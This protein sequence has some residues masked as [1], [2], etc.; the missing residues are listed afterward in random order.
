MCEYCEP[1]HEKCIEGEHG[2][3]YITKHGE[4]VVFP[5]T[6]FEVC[7]VHLPIKFC[8]MCGRKYGDT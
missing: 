3:A 4:I 5:D 7:A 8:P 6:D 1:Y 2:N